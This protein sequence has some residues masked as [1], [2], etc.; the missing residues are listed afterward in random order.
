MIFVNSMSDLFHGEHPRQFLD[1]V[2]DAMEALARH[3]YQVLTKRSSLM[4]RYLRAG[5][6]PVTSGQAYQSRTRPHRHAHRMTLSHLRQINSPARFVS[7]EPL[8]APVGGESGRPCGAPSDA[9]RMGRRPSRHLP[10]R[11]CR[12]AA[13]APN[14]AGARWTVRPGTRSP[15]SSGARQLR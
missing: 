7:F 3:I 5:R 4:L 10:A 8:L 11:R 13:P 2:W 14:Q 1:Q 15:A 6:C 9:P 12:G